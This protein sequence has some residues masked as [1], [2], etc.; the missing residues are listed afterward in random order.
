M[1]NASQEGFS[2]K[3][4]VVESWFR[5]MQLWDRRKWLDSAFVFPLE[6]KENTQFSFGSTHYYLRDG[7]YECGLQ[8]SLPTEKANRNH[9]VAEGK[10]RSLFQLLLQCANAL[11]TTHFPHPQLELFG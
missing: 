8:A 6:K 5:M 10:Y 9:R 11:I 7:L 2:S 1:S 3:E 4:L